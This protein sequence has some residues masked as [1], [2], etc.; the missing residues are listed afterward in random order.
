M[1]IER[2]I[3]SGGGT[4]GHVFPALAIAGEIRKRV[5]DSEILFVGAAD[6]MEMEKVPA[7]G[8]KIIGLPVMGLPRKAGISMLK[9]VVRLLRSY[10]QA[11]KI[12]TQF[13]PQIVIG[14]GGFASGPLLQAAA[15]KGIPYLIQ[16]QNSYAGITNKMLSKNAEAVC[17]AFDGMEKYFPP[18][19]IILIGN[20][21][22]E[23][24]ISHQ[25]GK[26][27]AISFFKIKEGKKVILIMGGSLGARSLN[28]AVINNLDKI[29]ESRK[30]EFIWQ[31]GSIYFRDIISLLKDKTPENLYILE[32][33]SRMDLAYELA[34]VVVSRAG[35]GAIAELSIAG[36]PAIFVPSP[37][38][39]EDHQTRNAMALVDK[40]AARMIPD[41]EIGEKLVPEAINLIND[42]EEC[43]RMSE[44]IRILARPDATRHIVDEAE[45]ILEKWKALKT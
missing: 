24:L 20:P 40:K 5:P 42:P 26:D 18:D 29:A 11:R 28:D 17:V 35:A 3:I 16:E 41:K 23:D 1:N 13:R 14:V 34:G 6:R 12:I 44:K 38:V 4:G 10:R 33:I 8:Y 39:A 36:K 32:F 37:N 21:V 22:R 9:F 2:I 31:T 30:V 45:K 19:K 25:S 27:E 43:R 15:G 7:A